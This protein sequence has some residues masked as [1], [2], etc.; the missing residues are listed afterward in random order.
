MVHVSASFPDESP[1][2]K[3]PEFCRK[4]FMPEISNRDV[5]HLQVASNKTQPTFNASDFDAKGDYYFIIDN[6]MYLQYYF[7]SSRKAFFSAVKDSARL[8]SSLLVLVTFE[9]FCD[10]IVTLPFKRSSHYLWTWV[11][12]NLLTTQTSIPWSWLKSRSSWFHYI[13]RTLNDWFI[14]IW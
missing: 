11:T 6:D 10:E 7:L 12:W 2:S 3:A 4:I 1:D 8:S 13:N 5:L 9:T 14:L